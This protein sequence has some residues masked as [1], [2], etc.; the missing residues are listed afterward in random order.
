MTSSTNKIAQAITIVPVMRIIIA[1]TITTLLSTATTI[2]ARSIRESLI[3]MNEIV[4]HV[5]FK[6]IQS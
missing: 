2:P 3:G 6:T 1:A 4:E 5:F